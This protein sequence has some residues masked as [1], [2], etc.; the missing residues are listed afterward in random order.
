MTKVRE[1]EEFRRQLDETQAIAHIGSWT[2]DRATDVVEFSDEQYRIYGLEPQSIHVDLETFIGMI[3]EEDQQAMR[4]AVARCARHGEPFLVTHRIHHPDGSTRWIEGRG[5]AFGAG[6]ELVRMVGTCNDVTERQRYEDE[7]RATLAEVQA[8]RARIVD[9]ADAERRRVERALHDGAQQRLVTLSMSLRLA[10]LA[11][12]EGHESELG[13]MLEA[14][15]AE[16]KAALE[17][18][19]DLAHGIHPALLADRGLAAALESLA[20]RSP[21]PVTVSC[22]SRRLPETVEVAAYYL[23]AESLTNA[24]K[25][26]RANEVEI[27]VTADP[28]THLVTVEVADDGIGGAN[29]GSGSG[30]RGLGDR[31][32]ALC[33]ELSVASPRGGGTTIRAVL[34]CA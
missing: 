25:H 7:F 28:A 14:A 13:Q 22:P 15:S 12:P 8:S 20:L 16:L 24:I 3:V 1:L 34:P 29:S 27:A 17:E 31:V 33:G 26:S 2:W 30:I 11:V 23:V 4:D 19:R 32:A 21:V 5:R 9:A 18:L 6:R 10:R